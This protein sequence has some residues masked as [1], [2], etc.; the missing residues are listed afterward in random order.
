MEM[1]LMMQQS[2]APSIWIKYSIYFLHW[3]SIRDSIIPF[4]VPKTT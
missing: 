3:L 1:E 4:E 2:L